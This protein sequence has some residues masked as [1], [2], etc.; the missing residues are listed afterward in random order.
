MEGGD[1]YGYETF[2]DQESV[3]SKF[4]TGRRRASAQFRSRPPRRLSFVIGGRGEFVRAR[5]FS[6]ALLFGGV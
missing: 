1:Y 4:S 2:Y 6:R 5:G 3:G